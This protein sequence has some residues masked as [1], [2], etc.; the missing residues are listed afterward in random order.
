MKP[1]HL[2][3]AISLSSALMLAVP[4]VHA[5]TR[6]LGQ[7]YWKHRREAVFLFLAD[8]RYSHRA[9]QLHPV[10]IWSKM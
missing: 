3:L 7:V 4:A 5:A 8:V 10:T 2:F 6:R 9:V 1:C